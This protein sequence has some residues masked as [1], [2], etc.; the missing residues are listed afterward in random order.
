MIQKS[1]SEH[2]KKYMGKESFNVNVNKG[3][4][5]KIYSYKLDILV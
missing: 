1:R 5:K 3:H 2:R 4:N